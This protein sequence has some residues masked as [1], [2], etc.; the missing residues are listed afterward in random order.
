[1]TSSYLRLSSHLLSCLPNCFSFYSHSPTPFGFFPGSVSL[2]RQLFLVFSGKLAPAPSVWPSL[3]PGLCP[4]G[5]F[6]P[7]GGVLPS[8]QSPH[9]LP[10]PGASAALGQ[11]HSC[12]SI[13]LLNSNSL[14][15]DYRKNYVLAFQEKKIGIFF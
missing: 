3:C 8:Q 1:M 14:Q 7:A 15:V 13:Q 9:L 2:M 12:I 5:G 11:D 6:S 10:Q 4:L